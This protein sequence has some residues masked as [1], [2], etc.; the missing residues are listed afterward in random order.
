MTQSTLACLT[1]VILISGPS[2]LAQST[3]RPTTD[4]SPTR[5]EA[6]FVLGRD[7]VRVNPDDFRKLKPPEIQKRLTRLTA[8]TGKQPDFK[9]TLACIMRRTAG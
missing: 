2:A 9:S 3:A 8:R 5:T 1:L 4:P 6:C 7:D